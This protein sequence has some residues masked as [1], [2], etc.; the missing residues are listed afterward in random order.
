MTTWGLEMRPPH[1]A[2]GIS[3]RE[4]TKATIAIGLATLG[5]LRNV[6][7][8]AP[9]MVDLARISGHWSTTA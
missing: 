3:R 2:S 9:A 4:L 1:T 5:C 8:S 6:K 7:A